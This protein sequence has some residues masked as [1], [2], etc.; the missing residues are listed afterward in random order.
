[1]NRNTVLLVF[2]DPVL[3]PSAQPYGATILANRLRSRAIQTEVVWPFMHRVPAEKVREAYE[4]VRPRVVGFSFRNLDTAGFHYEDD[5][6]ETFLSDLQDVV[7]AIPRSHSVVAIGGAGFSIAPAE[8]LKWTGAD[9]G[10][11]GPSEGDFAEFCDRVIRQGVTV[12]QAVCGLPSAFT[13]KMKSPAPQVHQLSPPEHFDNGA[14]EY[15]K[16]VG[17]TVPLRTKSGCSLRC[18]YCVVPRIEKLVLRPWEDIRR[19]L[20]RVRDA[21]LGERVF[22]ADGEFNLPS[23][24]HTIGLCRS[25]RNEFGSSINWRC[26]LEA[27]YVT[28]ELLAAMAESGCVGISLTVDSLTG[29]TRRGYAKGTSQSAAINAMELCLSSGIQTQI[30]LLFGG[31]N[32]TL[33]SALETARI[34][35]GFNHR[36]IIVAVT[37]G[38]RVYPGTPFA[39]L[40]KLPRY[41][42]HHR[43]C[44]SV[45]WLGVFCSPMSARE[46]ARH[47]MPILPP[48][49]TTPYTN[50]VRRSDKGA[51]HEVALGTNLLVEGRFAEAEAYFKQLEQKYSERLEPRLG[52]LK[53]QYGLA[54]ENAS[55]T[56]VA[57]TEAE[58]VLR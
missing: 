48:S 9:V 3:F 23:V 37:I 22:I 32:E 51:Y 38:L 15:A 13:P 34:A 43:P 58:L 53:A 30:N 27:G 49:E 6:E 56:S 26:Y 18:T 50:T 42:P 41:A 52:I 40:V 7:R 14:I 25:I 17:G 19:E 55:S 29:E 44:K 54:G 36:G 12:D 11:V 35:R 33:E 20:Q 21:G 8:I 46:L 24:E 4:R 31:P 16:M 2:A 57:T 45:D 1:M 28:S 39:K 47:I 5:G 10:F